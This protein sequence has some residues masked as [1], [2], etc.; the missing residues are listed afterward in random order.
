MSGR[1]H[2]P[3]PFQEREGRLYLDGLD[4]VEI[5]SRYGTPVYVTSSGRIRENYRRIYSAFKERYDNFSV[6]YAVK[7]NSNPH[8]ISVLAGEGAGADVSN[9][10]ELLIAEKSGIPA[11]QILMSPNNLSRE[12]LAKAS[13]RGVAINFDDIGQMEIISDSLPSLVS[14]RVNPGIGRGEFPGTVTA[15]PDAKFG[16]PEDHVIEAY[17]KAKD[18]GVRRFGIQMMTGSNVLDSGYFG[19]ITSKLF[20]ITRR[21]SDH[22]GIDFEFVDI[23]GGFGVPYRP[24]EKALPIDVVAGEVSRGLKDKFASVGKPLPALFVEPGRYLVADSTVLLGRITNVK[25]YGKTFIG[26]DVGMNTLLRPALYGAYHPVSIANKLD[27]EAKITA[28]VVGQICE[29]TDRIALD[30]RLPDVE[31]GDIL[32]VFNAGAYGFSMSNQ[33]N[34]HGKPAEVLV[35]DGK[36]KLIRRRENI[37]DL[38][39]TVVHD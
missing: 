17:R 31:E 23:G 11:K 26:T 29:N 18:H 20:D 19:A 34:G 24:D 14:F 7:A 6:K 15:G 10:N 30:R 32:A 5:A 12:E 16:I 27:H 28:D 39:Q 35:S 25:S 13:S 33:F 8:I 38:L 37:D 22:A 2:I 9:L 21:I 4:L 1:L 36:D 3:P